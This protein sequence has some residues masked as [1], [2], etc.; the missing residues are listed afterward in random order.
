MQ[1]TK[2]YRS[3][4]IAMLTISMLTGCQQP[5]SSEIATE[6]NICGYGID[7]IQGMVSQASMSRYLS[8][9]YQGLI[10][11]LSKGINWSP[12]LLVIRIYWCEKTI[13]P[14]P[15]VI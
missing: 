2:L 13:G 12:I 14:I 3:I 15:S 6:C 10:S 7:Q 8:A 5:V 9:P 1:N 4:L 11:T